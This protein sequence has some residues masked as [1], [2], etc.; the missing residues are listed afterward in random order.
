VI[1]AF[2]VAGLAGARAST[3]GTYRSALYRLAVPVHGAPGQRATPFAGAPAWGLFGPV[4]LLGGCTASE[5]RG[6]GLGW[7]L[8]LV[9]PDGLADMRHDVG[10][11]AVEVLA[12]IPPHDDDA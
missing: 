1:E 11:E 12:V 8:G 5:G 2:C 6:L 3:R 7:L 10:L 9:L 4:S